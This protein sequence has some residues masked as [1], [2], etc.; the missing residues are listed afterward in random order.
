[1][2]LKLPWHYQQ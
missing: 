1:M 2:M